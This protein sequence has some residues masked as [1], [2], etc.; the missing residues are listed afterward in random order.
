MRE[1]GL[2]DRSENLKFLLD[3]VV[4]DAGSDSGI[5]DE[6]SEMTNRL[7]SQIAQWNGQIALWEEGGE[8]GVRGGEGGAFLPQRAQ[9][10]TEV[11]RGGQM[12]DAVR[13]RGIGCFPGSCFGAQASACGSWK[14]EAV[15]SSSFSLP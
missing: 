6:V 13:V 15:G 8:M 7:H 10:F 14:F 9:R 5:V 3:R 12:L 2:T 1:I 11:H 4:C